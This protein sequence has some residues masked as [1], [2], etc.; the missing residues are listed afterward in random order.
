M[1]LKKLV[2]AFAEEAKFTGL[3]TATLHFAGSLRALR[4]P[5]RSR[6]VTEAL[7][8][9]RP[10]FDLETRNFVHR[11]RHRHYLSKR[12]STRERIDGA[13][14]HYRYELRHAKADYLREVY[15]ASGLVLW[16]TG[17]DGADFR[18]RLAASSDMRWEGASATSS[19]STACNSASCR[20]RGWMRASSVC[21][22]SR[23]CS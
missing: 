10:H 11:L 6:G 22:A 7:A 13:L 4:Y 2:E 17:V 19:R 8:L 14:H 21:R 20:F 16:Q 23:S 1:L 5:R 9:H 15:S 18:I 3:R 12:F